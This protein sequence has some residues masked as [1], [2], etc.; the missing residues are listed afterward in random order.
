MGGRMAPGA[1]N[2]TADL[3]FG[4]IEPIKPTALDG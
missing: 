3:G 2:A 1:N 4:F